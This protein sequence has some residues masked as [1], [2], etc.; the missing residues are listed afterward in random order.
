[1]K[2]VDVVKL[3]LGSV[4]VALFIWGYSQATKQPMKDIASYTAIGLSLTALVLK[5]SKYWED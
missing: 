5:K 3:V 2:L 4:L 1:M